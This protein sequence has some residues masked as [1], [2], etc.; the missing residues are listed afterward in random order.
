MN[1]TTGAGARF[2]GN[3]R[4]EDKE[5]LVLDL[6]IVNP[7]IGVK[8]ESAAHEADKTRKN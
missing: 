1:V 6:T 8:L 7:C 5:L 4:D 2:S 3:P